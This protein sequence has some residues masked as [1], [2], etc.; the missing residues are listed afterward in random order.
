MELSS[1]RKL[2]D[3]KQELCEQQEDDSDIG[4]TGG[5]EEFGHFKVLNFN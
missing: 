4:D 2:F 5:T 3:Q 1:F